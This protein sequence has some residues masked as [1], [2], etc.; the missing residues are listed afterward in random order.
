MFTYVC[1]CLLPLKTMKG[2]CVSF[3]LA[4]KR[5]NVPK[6]VSVEDILFINIS[7]SVFFILFSTCIKNLMFITN[8]SQFSKNV[9]EMQ[10]RV[11]RLFF[12]CKSQVTLFRPAGKQNFSRQKKLKNTRFSKQKTFFMLSRPLKLGNYYT[13]V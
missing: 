10:A 13:F 12:L 7:C 2:D 5:F 6:G 3:C 8:I 9:F 4:C 11:L 1:M